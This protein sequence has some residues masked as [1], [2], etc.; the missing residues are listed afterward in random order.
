MLVLV[1]HQSTYF[2]FFFR[3]VWRER[4]RKKSL[5]IAL[6]LLDK[7]L[8]GYVDYIFGFTVMTRICRQD[9]SCACGDFIFTPAN[10]CITELWASAPPYRLCD[11]KL[12]WITLCQEPAG[13]EEVKLGRHFSE[14]P[15]SAAWSVA[16][17]CGMK[18]WCFQR[19]GYAC[20]VRN[21]GDKR[22]D[23]CYKQIAHA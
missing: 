7:N 20:A 8:N 9:F 15:I 13:L 3:T 23:I 4:R 16:T 18:L 22:V 19:E 21:I 5:V 14:S 2:S 10:Q 6:E 12:I 11:Q 1:I 17:L